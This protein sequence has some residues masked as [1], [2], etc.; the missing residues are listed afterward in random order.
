M[1]KI[2][3]KVIPQY[4][5]VGAKYIAD[6][7][8]EFVSKWECEQYEARLKEEERN[9]HFLKVYNSIMDSKRIDGDT[10]SDE[11]VYIKRFSS[12]EEF[13][14]TYKT[15]EHYHYGGTDHYAYYDDSFTYLKEECLPEFPANLVIEFS[16]V[17]NEDSCDIEDF[18]FIEANKYIKKLQEKIDAVKEVIENVKN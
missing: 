14:E 8:K 9:K 12:K 5:E 18:N 15:L 17:E 7:G 2:D 13:L 3:G 1:K 16:L 11:R 10:F 6:D 4:V